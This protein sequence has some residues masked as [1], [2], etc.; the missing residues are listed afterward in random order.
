ME[1]KR[2]FGYFCDTKQFKIITRIVTDNII[3]GHIRYLEISHGYWNTYILIQTQCK[4]G[5]VLLIQ[6]S[7]PCNLISKPN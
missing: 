1:L 5:F 4:E 2:K 3:L 7:F 6:Q